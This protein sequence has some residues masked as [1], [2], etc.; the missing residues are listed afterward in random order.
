ME[1]KSYMGLEIHL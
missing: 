1:S